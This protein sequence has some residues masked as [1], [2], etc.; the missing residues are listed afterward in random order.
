MRTPPRVLDDR[1]AVGREA[2]LGPLDQLRPRVARGGP[3][4][5]AHE[6]GR[7]AGPGGAVVGDGGRV[8]LQQMHPLEVDADLAGRHL[9]EH[10]RRALADLGAAAGHRH[11]AVGMDPQDGRRHRLGAGVGRREADAPDRGPAGSGVSQPSSSAARSRSAGQVG[12]D[13]ADPRPRALPGQ[14]HVAA[15]DLEAV[16][17]E[18][19]GR[20]VHLRFAGER[21]LR[22]AEP[23]ERAGR[24]GVRVDRR[25]GDLE[26]R[27]TVRPA[28][29]VGGLATRRAASSRRRPRCRGG[30]SPGGRGCGRRDRRRCAAGPWPRRRAWS[31][32]TPRWT[33]RAGRAARR[34]GP[35]PRSAARSWC[36]TCC[37]SRPRRTGRSTRTADSGRSK[38]WARSSRTM[39][40]CWPEVQ[41]VRSPSPQRAIALYGSIAYAYERG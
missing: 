12:V 21:D 22:G 9:G 36:R 8:A 18:P 24:R 27:D 2:L 20:L 40:G 7:P 11:G 35:R 26:G 3:D 32:S 29:P 31:G 38:Q 23:A 5:Q 33:A 17:A 25:A 28:E 10:R 1:R 30:S 6:R 39:Y 34:E 14:Q 13:A 15:P 19:F 16:E 41:T 37:R 4:R